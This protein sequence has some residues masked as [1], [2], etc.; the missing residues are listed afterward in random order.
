MSRPAPTETAATPARGGPASPEEQDQLLAW[1]RGASAMPEPHFP[2]RLLE[3][4]AALRPEAPAIIEGERTWTFAQLEARANRLGH[5]LRSHGVGPEVAV[6]VAMK[7]SSALVTTLFAI[8]KAGGALLLLDPSAPA[9]RAARILG[10]ARARVLVRQRDLAPAPASPGTRVLVWEDVEADLHSFP[11]T[12]PATDPA[13]TDAGYLLQTS[14]TTGV[15]K[16]AVESFGFRRAK[17]LAG[18]GERVILKSSSGTTFTVAECLAVASGATLHVLPDSGEND[19]IHLAAFVRQHE[20]S[21]LIL[22]SSALRSLLDLEDFRACRALRRVVCIGEMVPA[23]LR[24]LCAER[25]PETQLVVGYGCTEGRLCL[26]RVCRPDDAPDAVDVGRPTPG[27]EVYILDRQRRLC[28]VGVPGELHIGGQIARGYLGDPA[29][30]AAQ[31]VP[32]PFHPSPQARLFATRDRARVLP[33]GAVE[34]LGRLDHQVKIR[35]YRVELGEVETA[36]AA[37]PDVAAAAVVAPENRD[38]VR[39]LVA[40]LVGTSRTR[41][42]ADM[43]RACRGALLEQLPHYMV[44][45]RI[46]LRGALPLNAAGKLDRQE[47]LRLASAEPEP[48]PGERV[49]LPRT[50]LERRLAGIWETVLDRRP[51]GIHEPFFEIGGDSLSAVRLM[52]EV[53]RRLGWSLSLA[54]LVAHPTIADLARLAPDHAP[55][56]VPG[57]GSGSGPTAV[58]PIHGTGDGPVLFFVPGIPGVSFVPQIVRDRAAA[59]G[60]FC[61]CLQFPGLGPGETP[62]DTVGDLAREMIRR[63]RQVLPVGPMALAGYSLGGVVAFEMARQLVAAGEPP[64]LVLLYDAFTPGVL[65]P[66]TRGQTLAAAARHLWRLGPVRFLRFVVERMRQKRQALRSREL[67]AL[68]VAPEPATPEDRARKAV[69][70]ASFRATDTLQPGPP[71]PGRVVLLRA[72]DREVS[73]G[74][75]RAIAIHNGWDKFVGDCFTVEDVP[76]DHWHLFQEANA[77]LIAER[78]AYWLARAGTGSLDGPRPASL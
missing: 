24:R 53:R 57:P 78:T 35:G 33:G 71:Y 47:L 16:I 26:S 19:L 58:N 50:E 23:S 38:G 52:Y 20:I 72:R 46:I 5:L 40:F 28:P 13:P 76:G 45:S 66:R 25:R 32:H 11:D 60:R 31:F 41:D 74:V 3:E 17:P 62:L 63:A 2:H 34:I 39:S 75:S 43:T 4:Q 70:D 8:H 1:A 27:M 14:G 49:D 51:I 30:T 12:P 6:A 18:P 56:S 69:Y 67:G 9:L 68:A 55:G 77:S 48:R 65:S 15:P 54:S 61:D 37:L 73:F 59:V 42:A 29:A 7:R 21:L 36:L 44:P 64:P 22:S 10:I